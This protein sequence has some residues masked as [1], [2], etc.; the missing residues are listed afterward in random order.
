MQKYKI[1]LIYQKKSVFLHHNS[2]IS[3]NSLTK[4]RKMKK[5][6][7]SC[8]ELMEAIQQI[9]LVPL[10]DSGIPG[11]SPAHL[12]MANLLISTNLYGSAEGGGDW[13]GGFR[14]DDRHHPFCAPPETFTR[15]NPES[16]RGWHG[17]YVR[18][19]TGPFPS[20]EDIRFRDDDTE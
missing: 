16:E 17:P 20:A 13:W 3:L 1:I 6:I 12:R 10:L 18:H 5:R 9:G 11:F 8:P 7:S 4:R 2:H 19:A 15:W 14:V